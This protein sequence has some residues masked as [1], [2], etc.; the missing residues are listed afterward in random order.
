M[1][2]LLIK[3]LSSHLGNNISY[4]FDTVQLL[5]GEQKR[6]E[7]ILTFF[8]TM[9]EGKF[10]TTEKTDVYE[11]T[12]AMTWG[13]LQPPFVDIKLGA[14]G[15]HASFK[16]HRSTATLTRQV[17]CHKH[18]IMFIKSYRIAGSWSVGIAT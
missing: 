11:M 5:D 8:L 4:Q 6:K 12:I 10:L 2:R 18:S 16:Q 15:Y 1:S 3:W 14:K 17:S 13:S 9:I 7:R